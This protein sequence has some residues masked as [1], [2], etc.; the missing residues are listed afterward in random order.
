MPEVQEATAKEIV[1]LSELYLDGTLRLSLGAD[2]RAM[3]LS[4]I[5][6]A[7]S[8]ALVVAGVGV[9]FGNN[10]IDRNPLA[11]VASLIAPATCFMVALAYSLSA[12]APRGFYV[13]GNYISLWSSDDDLYGPLAKALIEQAHVYEDQI[14]ENTNNLERRSSSITLALRYMRLAPMTA[15]VAGVVAYAVFDHVAKLVD[16]VTG[17]F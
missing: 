8:T 17:L 15:I 2:S 5:L 12:A 13:G 4:G 7:L 14:N 10:Q 9:F 6:G 1:R 16:L 3:Q 11:K